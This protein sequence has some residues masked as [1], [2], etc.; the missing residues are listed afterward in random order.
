MV[1]WFSILN[2]LIFQFHSLVLLLEKWMVKWLNWSY[3]CVRHVYYITTGLVLVLVECLRHFA[4]YRLFE[5]T[6]PLYVCLCTW[7]YH[8]RNSIGFRRLISFT[9]FPTLHFWLWIQDILLGISRLFEA[10]LLGLE[11]RLSSLFLLLG[12][13]ILWLTVSRRC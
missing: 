4:R 9:F 1:G 12:K 7:S 10:I 2:F 8:Y 5:A 6:L 3:L 11:Q 13:L